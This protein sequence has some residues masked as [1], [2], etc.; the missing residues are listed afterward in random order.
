M[1]H[2]HLKTS[3]NHSRLSKNFVQPNKKSGIIVHVKKNTQRKWVKIASFSGKYAKL[4][5]LNFN[6]IHRLI[7]QTRD[8]CKQVKNQRPN[9]NNMLLL[10][11][12]KQKI[13]RIVTVMRIKLKVIIILNIIITTII[14]AISVII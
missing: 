6:K 12:N 8:I 14:I 10:P 9:N 5:E 7:S 13:K 2:N 1:F 11:S 4:K 3:Y